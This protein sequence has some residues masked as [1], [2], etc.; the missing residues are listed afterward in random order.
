VDTGF[1]RQTRSEH[2]ASITF[3][4]VGFI[5]SNLDVI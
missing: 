3:F 2:F 5:Q 4:E 1:L